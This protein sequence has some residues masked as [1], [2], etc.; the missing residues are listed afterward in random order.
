[1]LIAANQIRSYE[2]KTHTLTLAPKARDELAG[3][4]LKERIVSGIPFAVA[5]GGKKAYAA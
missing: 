4:L 5:V 3:R 1:M 2:W